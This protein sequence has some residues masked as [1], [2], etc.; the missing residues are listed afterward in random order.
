[1]RL[2]ADLVE[3]DDAR[4]AAPSRLL[5]RTLVEGVD[6]VRGYFFGDRE[7]NPGWCEVR[8]VV[9]KG[10]RREVLSPALN[11]AELNLRLHQ[12]PRFFNVQLPRPSRGR[13]H[14]IHMIPIILNYS[15]LCHKSQEAAFAASWLSLINALGRSRTCTLSLRTGLLSS[16]KLRGLFYDELPLKKFSLLMNALTLIH[17]Y[18]S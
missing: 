10:T 11:Y 3:V 6:L 16:I 7:D 15:I 13:D 12:N 17:Y 4:D 5:L 1:M 9:E 8:H 2:S 18:P 14:R